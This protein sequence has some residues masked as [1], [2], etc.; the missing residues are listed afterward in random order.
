MPDSNITKKALAGALKEL[1]NE[2]PFAKISVGDI[3]QRCGMNRKSFYYHFRDK[4]DLVNW[5]FDYEFDIYPKLN[6]AEKGKWTLL[7]DVCSYMYENKS[8]YRKVLRINEQNCFSEHFA[9]ILFPRVR[10]RLTETMDG[11]QLEDMFVR[12]F[13][14]AIV[15]AIKRWL[16]EREPMHPDLFIPK[17]KILFVRSADMIKNMAE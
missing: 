5:I 6:T 12:F 13:C 17:L 7:E 9:E 14:D 15:C 11:E 8:F 16:L 4:Y 1:L 10:M 2:K 3:C